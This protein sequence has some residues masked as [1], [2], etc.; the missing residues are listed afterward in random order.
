[1][2]TQKKTLDGAYIAGFGIDISSMLK[3]Q[4]KYLLRSNHDFASNL[5]VPLT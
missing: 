1:M 2:K 5:D 3:W 4:F